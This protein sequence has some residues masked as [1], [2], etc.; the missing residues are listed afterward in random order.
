MEM[1]LVFDSLRRF[2]ALMKLSLFLFAFCMSA[3]TAFAAEVQIT[4]P[5]I[6]EQLSDNK[7]QQIK[8]ITQ[9]KIE[10]VFLRGGAT[11]FIVDGQ[12]QLGQWKIEGDKYCSAWPPSD[13]WD[14]YDILQDGTA[15]IFLSGHGARFIMVPVNP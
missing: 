9:H 3:A 10:Q 14:C 8:P 12:V 4:G 5:Q 15:L 2:D 7:F 13:S 6:Q 11:Q 1:T